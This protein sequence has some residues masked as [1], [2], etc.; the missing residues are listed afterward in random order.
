MF[1]SSFPSSSS[2]AFPAYGERWSQFLCLCL[3]AAYENS[4]EAPPPYVGPLPL[5]SGSDRRSVSVPRPSRCNYPKRVLLFL[6]LCPAPFPAP[7]TIVWVEV[8][9]DR[10]RESSLIIIKEEEESHLFCATCLSVWRRRQWPR[11][12]KPT[13][14]CACGSVPSKVFRHTIYTECLNKCRWANEW[15]FSFQSLLPRSGGHFPK[16]GD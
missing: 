2:G 7:R 3:A 10:G 9:N 6:L 15:M 13:L 16:I 12:E 11:M 1:L 14:C 5:S 8:S 4:S